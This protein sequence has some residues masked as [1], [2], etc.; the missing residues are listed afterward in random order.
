M[1]LSDGKDM[2]LDKVV[3]GTQ[4]LCQGVFLKGNNFL[5]RCYSKL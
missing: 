2:R 3:A 4:I 1:S 5:D